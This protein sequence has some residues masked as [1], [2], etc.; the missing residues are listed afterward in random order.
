MACRSGGRRRDRAPG[1]VGFGGEVLVELD[2]VVGRGHQP[3]FGPR[4]GSAASGE[5]GEAAVVLQSAEDRLDELA[6]LLVKL[7][8]AL[9][10]QDA[11]HE[12]IGTA[13]GAW[14][15]GP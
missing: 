8:A 6:A 9:G 13:V 10:G 1:S 2:E 15:E 7:A 3:P 5:A 14:S 12:V 4:G 11:A